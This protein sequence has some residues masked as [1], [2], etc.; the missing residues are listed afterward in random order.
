LLVKVMASPCNPSDFEYL[1]GTYG[2]PDKRPKPPTI[3]GL[4][5]SGVVESVGEGVDKGLAGKKV[6]IFCE[7]YDFKSYHGNWAQYTIKRVEDI[8]VL[9]D[10]SMSF[11]DTCY[12]FVNTM[13]IMFM[14]HII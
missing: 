6:G 2:F 11:E 8:Y 9:K 1:T 10:Q 7:T 5:G 13:S 12:L 3:A 14:W 4:E